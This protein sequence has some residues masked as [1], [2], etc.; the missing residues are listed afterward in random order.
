MSVFHF[1]ALYLE[2]CLSLARYS[3]LGMIKSHADAKS[4]QP[5]SEEAN[6]D[7]YRDI[8]MNRQPS[9]LSDYDKRRP[10]LEPKVAVSY[11]SK[12][13]RTKTK[14]KGSVPASIIEDI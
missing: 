4:T 6:E 9:D 12:H 14:Q 8:V 5:T 10:S 3:T 11:S 1:R 7:T 13:A 2:S